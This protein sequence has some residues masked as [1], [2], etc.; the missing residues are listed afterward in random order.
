MASDREGSVGRAGSILLVSLA[1][2]VSLSPEARAQDGREEA[3]AKLAEGAALF[4]RGDYAG[5]LARFNEAHRIYPSPK[6]HFNIAESY[7][8]MARNVEAIEAYRRFLAEASDVSGEQRAEAER[9]VA[10]LSRRV[11]ALSVEADTEGARILVDGRLFGTTPRAEPIL[12]EAGP[13]QVVVEKDGHT[14][15]LERF[16]GMPGRRHEVR[17]R[18]PRASLASASERAVPAPS[19][20]GVSAGVAE[21]AGSGWRRV[22]VG[23]VAAGAAS[24]LAAGVVAMVSASN[25]RQLESRCNDADGCTWGKDFQQAEQ[26]IATNRTV[27]WFLAGGGVA[28]IVGGGALFLWGRSDEKP[29]HARLFVMGMPTGLGLLADTRW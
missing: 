24:L 8:A 28:A 6:L 29:R 20:L 27:E 3:R 23:L 14:S 9:H 11:S 4:D 5:A 1:A 12:L 7:R 10:D 16:D 21:G 18:L 19:E 26:A 17:A 2:W 13:H 25:A 22:G 15:H